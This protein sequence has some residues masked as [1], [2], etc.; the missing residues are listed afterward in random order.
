MSVS[1][2]EFYRSCYRAT[3]EL[4]S[5]LKVRSYLWVAR[6]PSNKNCWRSW[7]R[8][9][10][11][12]LTLHMLAWSPILTASS[13]WH[14]VLVHYSGALAPAARVKWLPW[15][16]GFCKTRKPPHKCRFARGEWDEA[17]IGQSRQVSPSNFP[18]P[19]HDKD[20]KD[21]ILTF[22]VTRDFGPT[23][24][25]EHPVNGYIALQHVL[26]LKSVISWNVVVR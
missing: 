13:P 9:V 17:V 15:M 24:K 25:K 18:G 19:T 14:A 2:S 3:H 8:I 5:L 21:F 26:H 7:R 1:W 12:G 10:A 22:H 11:F 23:L 6:V 20:G 4:L 16:H